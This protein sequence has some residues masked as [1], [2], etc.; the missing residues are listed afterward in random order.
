LSVVVAH[1]AE[2]G[3][4]DVPGAGQGRDVQALMKVVV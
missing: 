1:P 4:R 3:D 2:A